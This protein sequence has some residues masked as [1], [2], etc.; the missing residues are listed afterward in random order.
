MKTGKRAF[1]LIEVLLALLLFAV[2]ATSLSFA[3]RSGVLIFN[4]S[5]DDAG[6]YHAARHALSCFEKDLCNSFVF[7]PMPFI[8]KEKVVSFPAVVTIF[9]EDDYNT[10]PVLIEYIFEDKKFTRIIKKLKGGEIIRKDNFG[11]GLFFNV[12]FEYGFYDTEDNEIY[13]KKE[14]NTDNHV[15]IPH[16]LRLSA[17]IIRT[18]KD[19]K[20][21]K[22]T[23][24]RKIWIPHGGW[25]QDD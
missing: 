20:K 5:E 15:F 10:V 23:I 3:L 16:A 21:I 1:T 8:G 17:E 7:S 13:W 19:D 2:A 18:G 24:I 12:N 11:A 22:E 25:V 9:S 14:W 6:I 4:R